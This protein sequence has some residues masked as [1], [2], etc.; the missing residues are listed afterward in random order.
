MRAGAFASR[1]AR[2]LVPPFAIAFSLI[3]KYISFMTKMPA[4]VNPTTHYL[5]VPGGQIGYDVRGRGPLLL[6]LPGM[7][8]IRSS[9]RHLVPRLVEAGYTVATA[10]LRGH[11]DSDATFTS[12]G[13]VETASDIAA[14]LHH[15]GSPA[16]IVGNS[17]SAASAVIAA[18]DHPELVDAL[19]LL[20]PFVRNPVSRSAFQQRLFRVMM[21]GPWARPMWNAFVPKLYS[22]RKPDDFAA[23]RASMIA[24]MRRP[25]YTKAFSLTTRADHA[26]AERSLVSVRAPS[27]IV[28]GEQ[29]PDFDD[30]AAEASWIGDALSGAVVMVADA[31]HYPQSQQ[32][33]ATAEA[34]VGFLRGVQPNA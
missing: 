14:L 4:N 18:A 21:A 20:G 9:Y 23:Y 29:D 22:G 27:L 30:A 19:V 8:E 32:P 6:L 16:V 25:G 33:D 28:M 13:D 10:D 26:H 17:M 1:S 11:G 3:A 2:R 5:A 34:I 12:Y 7:G 31:G 15:L 24:A